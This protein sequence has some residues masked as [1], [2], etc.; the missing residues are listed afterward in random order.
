MASH[1]IV[2]NIHTQTGTPVYCN[3]GE[4]VSENKFIKI[5]I[6]CSRFKTGLPPH[7]GAEIITDCQL[8]EDKHVN[9]GHT[10]VVYNMIENLR[11]HW[12]S[13]ESARVLRVM[14]GI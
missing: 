3:N 2:G 7:T 4:L 14:T 9:S 10:P 6:L 12:L 5:R 8:E 1:D 11:Y 13:V